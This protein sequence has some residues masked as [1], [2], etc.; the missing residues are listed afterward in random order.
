[1]KKLIPVLI[2]ALAAA[3]FYYRGLWLPQS[4]G[5]MNYL[6]YVEGETILIAAP[7]AGRIIDMA[8][9]KGEPIHKSDPVFSLDTIAAEAE[10]SRTE[11]A[12][13]TAKAEAAD[14]L[15]GKR[16]PE[17]EVIRAQRQQAQANLDLAK[18]TLAR[19]SK[20]AGTGTTAEMNLDQA[21]PGCRQLRGPDRPVRCQH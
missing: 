14:L 2:V 1:M 15:T 18:L 10:V 21:Q 8:A 4:P 13:V 9:V 20:L 3:L 6:G 17:I 12:I 19:T 7:V 5:S 11:A 16:Q